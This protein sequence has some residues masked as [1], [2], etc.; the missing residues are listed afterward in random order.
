[1]LFKK[2]KQKTYKV[3][4]KNYSKTYFE[5]GVKKAVLFRGIITKDELNVISEITETYTF[6]CNENG[7]FIELPVII[8]R[9]FF[10]I[11]EKVKHFNDTLLLS[12][13]CGCCRVYCSNDCKSLIV[14]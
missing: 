2:N 10:I 5:D 11:G 7:K 4:P 6:G 14:M 13:N 3:L 1:M 9:R 12:V 8:N